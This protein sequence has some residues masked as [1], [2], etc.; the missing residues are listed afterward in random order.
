MHKKLTDLGYPASRI[1]R[2]PDRAGAPRARLDLRFIG[3]HLALEV[4]ATGSEV[5]TEA[6]GVPETEDVRITDVARRPMPA[7]PTS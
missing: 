7:A 1:H 3:S 2:M 6:F 4:T 5:I